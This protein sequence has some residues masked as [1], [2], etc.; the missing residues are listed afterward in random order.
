MCKIVKTHGEDLRKTMG[1]RKDMKE[2]GHQIYKTSSGLEVPSVTTIVA[3]R[4]KSS[5]LVPWANKLGL[6]GIE[7]K[8]YIDE[9]AEIGSL[10]HRMILDYFLNEET[11]LAG[12]SEE[13]IEKATNSFISFLKWTK[14][15]EIK[16][17]FI[18]QSLVS[19]KE[20]FGG[21]PDFYGLL[22]GEKTIIDYNTGSRIYREYLYQLAGYSI[23]LEEAG[24]E[25][26]QVLIVRIPRSEDEEFS[27]QYIDT[28]EKERLIFRHLLAIY[29][30]EK[31]VYLLDT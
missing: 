13:V 6:Q 11:N 14:G 18:E 7:V 10:A 16:P 27:V 19:E 31:I 3:I 2:G 26:K 17:L 23:L 15:K 12:Y 29:Y 21:T 24:Y 1:W 25:V 4:D 22:D 28:L 5:V 9:K 20:L 30:L 8:Q